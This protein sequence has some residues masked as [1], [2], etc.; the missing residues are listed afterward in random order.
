[1]LPRLPAVMASADQRAHAL[2]R[3]V[4][5]LAEAVVLRPRAGERFDAVVVDSGSAHG[6]V[7]LRDP[8]VRARCDAADLPLGQPIVVRL[9]EVDLARRLVRFVPA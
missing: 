2:D 1:M 5:D 7:Q 8:A 3:A 6:V 9:A 4:V